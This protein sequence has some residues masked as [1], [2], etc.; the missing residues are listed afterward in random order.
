M[1]TLSTG[2]TAEPQQ[3]ACRVPGG[4]QHEPDGV[5]PSSRN[6]CGL[7]TGTGAGPTGPS[8]GAAAPPPASP[9]DLELAVWRVAQRM[10]RLRTLVRRLD[11]DGDDTLL[12]VVRA[13]VERIVGGPAAEH[14]LAKALDEEC[15]RR[16]LP[17]PAERR[18]AHHER[19]GNGDRL[20]ASARPSERLGLE[21][22]VRVGAD[23]V[24][25]YDALAS[26]ARTVSE[27]EVVRE[28]V[29]RAAS[30]IP[31]WR[32][33]HL[34]VVQTQAEARVMYAWATAEPVLRRLTG[35]W[36]L[37]TVTVPWTPRMLRD[38]PM[39][40]V[41]DHLSDD[42]R[43]CRDNL[44]GWTIL[45][46]SPGRFY[47]FVGKT[48][49]FAA[50]ASA[51]RNE[52]RADRVDRLLFRPAKGGQRVGDLGALVAAYVILVVHGLAHLNRLRPLPCWE[53]V[54]TARSAVRR[55]LAAALAAGATDCA[56]WSD[57][58]ATGRGALDLV[59]GLPAVPL[60]MLTAVA[61]QAMQITV[62][63]RSNS[64][65]FRAGPG[66][67]RR[68]GNRLQLLRRVLQRALKHRPRRADS[69][70][71]RLRCLLPDRLVVFIDYLLAAHDVDPTDVGLLAH[72][73][74]VRA[75]R[76]RG[77]APKG[78]ARVHGPTGP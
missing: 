78:G 29:R 6:A 58:E 32:L 73:R 43:G 69:P 59:A 9:S 41:L 52:D 18:R 17:A 34:T 21:P 77:P 4:G 30:R 71:S 40:V 55:S 26:L 70:F 19:A 20:Q 49:P 62:M 11:R 2:R 38:V 53:A 57:L 12:L 35:C 27:L 76:R 67:G 13:V 25:F 46:G 65:T 54:V 60:P 8:S 51:P 72:L 33:R 3:K 63:A 7:G 15:R 24:Q 45:L 47:S 37:P 56:A 14:V 5:R 74:W 66:I 50:A 36:L 61:D 31:G 1:A 44:R 23:A 39:T 42:P 48:R 68:R 16:G 10:P 75:V 22:A 64:G 28:V